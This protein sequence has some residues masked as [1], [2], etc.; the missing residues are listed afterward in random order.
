MSNPFI[1]VDEYDMQREG[2]PFD[3]MNHEREYTR[4]WL[5]VVNDRRLSAAQVCFAPGVPRPYTPYI[6]KTGMIHDMHALLG[7]LDGR[8]PD[9]ND[10]QRWIVTGK[11]STKVIDTKGDKGTDNRNPEMDPPDI[12]WDYQET[13]EAPALDLD[14]KPFFNS[15]LQPFAPAPTFPVGYRV[16]NYTKNQLDFDPLVADDYTFSVNSDKFMGM[17]PGSVLCLP[18]RAQMII[19]GGGG[20]A[21]KNQH[22]GMM[23]W[24]VSYRLKF[25][26]K[27]AD[28]KYETWQPKVLDQGI[29]E[30][31]GR[32][33]QP[34]Q[35]LFAGALGIANDAVKVKEVLVHMMDEQAIPIASPLCLDGKGHRLNKYL[36]QVQ[37]KLPDG[38][39][40]TTTR[41][42]LDPVWLR[43]RIYQAKSF[44][45]ILQQGF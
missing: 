4:K 40:I 41:W 31:V 21:G 6:D 8:Q 24:R 17:P 2:S 19:K 42:A 25:Q 3:S 37:D 33:E 45:R 34:A 13:Q 39:P 38:T 11:Y 23:Y 15:A 18:P 7:K 14:K 32:P 44:R 43:F 1:Y 9:E 36:K 20:G 5:V 28:G 10:W 26:R 16:L 29:S 27:D 12:S 35:L 30:L 22:N